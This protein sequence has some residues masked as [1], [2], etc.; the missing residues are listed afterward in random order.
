MKILKLG[1]IVSLYTIFLN[2]YFMVQVKSQ[3][4]LPFF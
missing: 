1:S 3:K 2:I 4:I